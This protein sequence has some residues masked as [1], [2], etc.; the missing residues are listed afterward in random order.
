MG[1]EGIETARHLIYLQASQCDYGQRYLFSK[2]L[3]AS[4]ATH[5]LNAG[6]EWTWKG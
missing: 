6:L 5:L 2:P 4:Q 3:T 1:A